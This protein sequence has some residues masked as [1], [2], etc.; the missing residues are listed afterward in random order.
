MRRA[1]IFALPSRYEGLGCVYLEAM[2]AGKPVIGCRGQGIEEVIEQG[3][4]GCL[5]DADD[6]AGLADILATLLQQE[7]LRRK[8]GEA[9]RQTIMQGYTHAQ[10]AARLSRLYRECR[11]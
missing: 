5:I 9:A 6:Q 10:Q 7:P 3:V 1:T 2:S 4:N 11:E 8:M